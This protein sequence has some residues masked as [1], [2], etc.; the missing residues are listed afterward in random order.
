MTEVGRKVAVADGLAEGTEKMAETDR[1]RL[2]G[3]TL[4]FLIF[5][6]SS[7]RIYIYIYIMYIRFLKCLEA[8]I[9]ERQTYYIL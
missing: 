5:I 1:L 8:N 3:R 4:D 2:K 7:C 6:L 9:F